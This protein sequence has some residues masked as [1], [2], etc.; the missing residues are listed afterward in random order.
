LNGSIPPPHGSD[1]SNWKWDGGTAITVGRGETI[2]SI[3]RKNG[4]PSSAIMQANNISA[5]ASLQPGQRLVIPR[6]DRN[7][8]ARATRVASN[9]SMVPANGGKAPAASA[10]TGATHVVAPRESLMTIARLYHKPRAVIAK[11]NNITADAKL[12]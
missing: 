5:P 6:Y 1:R 2:E 3:S 9:A 12:K 4:V 8:G 11:A 7:N 10:A